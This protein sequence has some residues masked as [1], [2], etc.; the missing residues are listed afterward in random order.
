MVPQVWEH[1]YEIMNWIELMSEIILP[2]LK[3]R[4]FDY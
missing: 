1:D 4:I 3:E 2:G